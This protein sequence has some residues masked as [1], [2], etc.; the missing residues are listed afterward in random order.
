M[1]AFKY[2]LELLK[3]KGWL[4]VTTILIG[5]ELAAIDVGAV[6]DNKYTVLAGGTNPHFPGVAKLINFHHLKYACERRFDQIDFLCGDFGWKERFLLT[7]RPLYE[8][9]IK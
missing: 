1:I 8:F 7:P 6:I 3:K 2:L 4:R 9:M 5:G